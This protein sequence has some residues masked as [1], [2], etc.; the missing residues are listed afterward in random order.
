MFVTLLVQKG[1]KINMF[2]VHEYWVDIGEHENLKKAE[3]DSEKLFD[4]WK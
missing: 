3:V 1:I 2:P 4:D